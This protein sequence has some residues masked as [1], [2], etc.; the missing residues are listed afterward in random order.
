VDGDEGMYIKEL[1]QMRKKP[2]MNCGNESWYDGY[3]RSKMQTSVNMMPG[4]EYYNILQ[5]DVR[6]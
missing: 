4:D 2:T 1:D 3:N 6:R 5:R